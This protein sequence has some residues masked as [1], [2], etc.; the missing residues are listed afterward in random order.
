[1]APTFNHLVILF[2]GWSAI[3]IAASL[4][5]SKLVSERVLSKW[6]REEQASIETI[7]DVVAKDRISLESATKSQLGIQDA[8]HQKRLAAID[9]LWRCT[10][11][12]RNHFSGVVFF[13]E[14]LMPDEYNT[15][16]LRNGTFASS[17]ENVDQD[18]IQ[19]KM[20]SIEMLEDT[21]PYLGETLWLRFF[22]YRAFLGRLAVLISD[23][24]KLKNI[25][26]WREDDGVRQILKNV[27]S[28][29][30]YDSVFTESKS[31]FPVNIVINTLE[32]LILEEIAQI[33]SGRHSA[34]ESFN[35]SQS[36]RDALSAL[37]SNAGTKLPDHRM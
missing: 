34:I 8:S 18:F 31:Y 24:K 32:S 20:S 27:L 2:G 14:I 13:F 10:R 26:S 33:I 17:I 16:G 28:S 15:D 5:S 19:E 9:Q 35:S 21:R 11:A 30:I 12:L 37:R 25:R 3:L 36:L 7:R 22:V 4:W 1:M 29:R 6:R 23:G